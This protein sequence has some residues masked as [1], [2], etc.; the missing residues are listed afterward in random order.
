[1]HI[2]LVPTGALYVMMS[3]PTP[4]HPNCRSKLRQLNATMLE[5]RC[6]WRCL[7]FLTVARFVSDANGPKYCICIAGRLGNTKVNNQR[8]GQERKHCHQRLHRQ[9]LQ[10]GLS[11]ENLLSKMQVWVFIFCDPALREMNRHTRETI[12]LGLK[13]NI[14]SISW[15]HV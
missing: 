6:P 2:F 11:F 1:M 14:P 4:E 12:I 3:S 15:L 7:M 8:C 9:K 5:H 13:P 10:Q